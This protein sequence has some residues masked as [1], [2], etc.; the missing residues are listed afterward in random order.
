MPDT[1][2]IFAL[3]LHP[4]NDLKKSLAKFV[5]EQNIRA[6]YVITAIGS[7]SVCNLRYAGQAEGVSIESKFEILALSGT[8]SINGLHLHIALADETAKAIGGHLLDGN[9][10]YTTAEIV[11][12]E[13]EHLLFNRKPDSETGYTELVV[14]N[15]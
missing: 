6:G 2:K 11:I 12:G 10:I 4:G 5:A 7:L 1:Q 9:I 8:L 15:R 3:R 13:A 14:E